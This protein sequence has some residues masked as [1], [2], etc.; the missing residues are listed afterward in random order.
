[1]RSLKNER[2]RVEVIRRLELLTPGSQPRWGRLTAPRMI[3]HVGDALRV[4]LG[5]RAMRPPAR[6][7]FTRF[8]FKHLFLY[9]I[10]MPRNLP[11]SRVLLSTAPTDF[12]RDREACADLVGRFASSPA[13]GR[14]PCHQVLGVLTWPEWGVLQWR[15][16]DHHL[17]QFGV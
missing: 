16:L 2:D 7:R 6:R 11:T 15:H 8:P 17:R 12:A 14:G 13:S 4:A 9:V 1:M 5:E 3:C 10:P